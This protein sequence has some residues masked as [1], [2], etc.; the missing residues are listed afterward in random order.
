MI[1]FF[2]KEPKKE[3]EEIEE[4][5]PP[6][7]KLTSK[8]KL[9]FKDKFGWLPTS[10]WYIPYKTEELNVLIEDKIGKKT[11]T[12]GKDKYGKINTSQ[13]KT[14]R[15]QFHPDVAMRIIQ[16]YSKEKDKILDP[17]AGRARAVIARKLGR[18]YIGYEVNKEPYEQI[19]KQLN[20]MFLRKDITT[21]IIHA[22]S[23]NITEKEVYDL[24]FSC[25]PYWNVEIYE[26]ADGDLS[27]ISN[28]DTFLEKLKLIITK[29]YEALKFDCF[30]VFVV[31]D[32]T[33][34]G[35]YY[36]F[37]IDT[38]NLFQQEGFKLHDIIIRHAKTNLPIKIDQAVENK[39]MVK[40]HEYILVFKK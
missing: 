2:V 36:A 1:N 10:I 29:C 12:Y 14:M 15:S 16:F 23:I 18:F 5:P 30:A 32:F 38:I 27:H 20:Q 6:E 8:K 3:I 24:V 9:L 19:N 13:A 35:H 33:R 26:G 37:H 40:E 17:F 39:K 28:Y 7:E 25:P 31:N 34:E 11:I 4:I 21:Q 22:D